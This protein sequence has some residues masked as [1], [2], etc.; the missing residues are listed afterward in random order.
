MRL[1]QAKAALVAAL[2][3]D[4]RSEIKGLIE[5]GA[6]V[7]TT[8]EQGDTALLAAVYA[9]DI[10]FIKRLIELGADV[11]IA[12]KDG[13]TALILAV[14]Y[15]NFNVVKILIG[16]GADVNKKGKLGRTA[17][18]EA[19]SAGDI[20]LIKGLIESGADVNTCN[21]IGDTTLMLAAHSDNT[22]VLKL[23]IGAGADVNKID[24]GW[25][26]SLG[27]TALSVAVNSGKHKNI[28]LLLE[29][30]ADV[31]AGKQECPGLMY[32]ILLETTRRPEP[33]IRNLGVNAKDKFGFPFI[34]LATREQ[35][36][37]ALPALIRE[38]ADVNALDSFGNTALHII[39]NKEKR[40]LLLAAGA[41]INVFNEEQ[42]NALRSYIF[43]GNAKA[44]DY[45]MRRVKK[46]SP[47]YQAP[48]R[49]NVCMLLYAA[50]E[51][52]D[53]ATV[54]GQYF[55]EYMT[56]PIAQCILWEAD[57]PRTV[58]NKTFT[59]PG[60]LLFEDLKLSLKH[61]CRETI[62]KCLLDTDLHT[63]IFLRAPKLGLPRSLVAYILYNQS[64][65]D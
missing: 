54:K 57:G 35:Y 48:L 29:A 8:D 16:A 13:E 55:S 28:E 20:E 58:V 62:R 63:N 64:L 42:H 60:C 25:C 65:Q 15:I 53:G 17:L 32:Q 26:K 4:D 24:E 44:L 37:R 22:N 21:N 36:G 23:L 14:R 40:C 11:N 61:L 10:G 41:R 49:Q 2:S 19:L 6:D 3:A 43:W 50:G 33:L 9:G 52:L 39:N 34:S 56:M 38:G 7:N 1:K 12:N 27:Q 31:N 59:V 45:R 5:S 18:M 51:T 47:E 30:G 46:Y